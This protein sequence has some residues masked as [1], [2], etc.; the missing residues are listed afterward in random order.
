MKPLKK[1]IPIFL[2][3]FL[4]LGCTSSEFLSGSKNHDGDDV[5]FTSKSTGNSEAKKASSD[6]GK[7]K[8]QRVSQ[9]ED[10][11][12]A[13]DY[14]DPDV[15]ARERANRD[16]RQRSY[17]RKGGFYGSPGPHHGYYG[18]NTPYGGYNSGLNM[19]Y[20]F[21]SF[22]PT[23]SI[24][25]GMGYS[26]GYGSGCSSG[27]G[28]GS[29]YG[30]YD[31]W[32]SW[33]GSHMA[34]HHGHHHHQNCWGHGGGYSYGSGFGHG[35]PYYG[36]GW[37]SYNPY[38]PNFSYPGQD[39]REDR[40][41]GKRGATGGASESGSRNYNPKNSERKRGAPG[42]APARNG[43]TPS[44]QG[45][46]A[47][48]KDEKRGL[49]NG[50]SAGDKTKDNNTPET[51]YYPGN[52]KGKPDGGR[53]EATPGKERDPN[54]GGIHK[55]PS[56]DDGRDGIKKSPRN[57][58]ERNIKPDRGGRRNSPGRGGDNISPRPSRR[59][60]DGD[61]NNSPNRQQRS[62]DPNRGSSGGGSRSSGGRRPPH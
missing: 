36:S 27:Y 9:E 62:I 18:R 3:P 55:R 45:G 32:N 8:T 34:Y 50:E 7:A 56:R 53:R 14:Y 49:Q 31:P 2:L 11:N 17:Q 40:Y 52:P 26:N 54:K 1:A 60:G 5:Y 37:N 35:Y 48:E 46:T 20:G 13:A 6:Q 19:G 21:G 41:Y 57:K 42:E 24:A 33:T 10:K 43:L 61:L 29:P 4:V 59:S 47:P 30:H 22:G 23:S 38:Y 28:Y 44:S 12:S 39:Q 25:Y 58:K 51:D 16:A 15:A